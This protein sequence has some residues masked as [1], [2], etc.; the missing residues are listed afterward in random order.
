MLKRLAIVAGVLFLLGAVA[1]TFLPTSP[2][3]ATCG[4]WVAPEWDEE[5]TDALVRDWEQL[6]DQELSP[7]EGT[8]DA[9]IAGIRAV[10]R[11]CDGAL[12]TRRTAT[13]VLLGLAVLVPAGVFFV[14]AGDRRQR[15]DTESSLR[16]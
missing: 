16:A 9:N 11:A 3:G 13:L 2:Q 10:Q 1:A 7:F 12:G 15:D 8:A 6:A 4:T 14:A 5:A